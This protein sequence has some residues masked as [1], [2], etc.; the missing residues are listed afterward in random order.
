MLET[1][2]FWCLACATEF[3]KCS[4]AFFL[5]FDFF[6]L[7]LYVGEPVER[8]IMLPRV[9]VLHLGSLDVKI[10]AFVRTVF[11]HELVFLLL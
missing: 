1:F 4:L 9:K 8:G 2:T 10:G 11:V 3:T 5:V 6:L 7:F